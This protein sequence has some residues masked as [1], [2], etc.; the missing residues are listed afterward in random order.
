MRIIPPVALSIS[1]LMQINMY[2]NTLSATAIGG[3]SIIAVRI[4]LVMYQGAQ[5]EWKR[6][7]SSFNDLPAHEGVGEDAQGD[8]ARATWEEQLVMLASYGDDGTWA[9][10]LAKFSREKRRNQEEVQKERMVMLDKWRQIV[11]LWSR[12]VKKSYFW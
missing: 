12:R 3:D 5:I 8:E 7:G 9:E 4:H 11:A 1:E 10:E 6:G 2:R